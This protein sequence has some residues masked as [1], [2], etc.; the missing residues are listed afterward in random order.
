MLVDAAGEGPGRAIGVNGAFGNLGV[1][2]VPVVTAF[3]ANEAGWRAAFLLPGIACAAVGLVWLRVPWHGATVR[4]ALR[5]FPAIPR[6]LV[7]RAVIMLMLIAVV[8][9]LVFN[10]FTLLLPKLLQER[11]AS[12]PDLLPL[13]GA[14]T[15]A[16]IVAALQERTGGLTAVMLVMAAFG[17]V[18]L[19]CALFFP[20]RKE[21]LRPELWEAADGAAVRVAAE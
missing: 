5:P 9:G 2:L 16:P 14:A 1:A 13:V 7:R 8:S 18:T 10:A 12:Q 11:L 6:H 17:T 19:G 21:E 20:D 3:L 15:C 4:R